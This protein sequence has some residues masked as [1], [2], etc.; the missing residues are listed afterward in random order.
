MYNLFLIRNESLIAPM[1]NAEKHCRIL[2]Y[3]EDDRSLCT[4]ETTQSSGR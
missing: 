4:T 3:V 1:E 2:L